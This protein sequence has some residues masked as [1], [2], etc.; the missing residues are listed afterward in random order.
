MHETCCLL[1]QTQL[2]QTKTF[3]EA[4][5]TQLN[6]DINWILMH[7]SNTI[8]FK[9]EVSTLKTTSQKSEI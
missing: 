8:K 3:I 7:S 6:P 9:T 1:I 5:F 4:D 2:A